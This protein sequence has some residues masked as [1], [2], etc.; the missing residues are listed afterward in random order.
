[1]RTRVREALPFHGVFYGLRSELERLRMEPVAAP[2]GL[3]LATTIFRSLIA[4]QRT[5]SPRREKTR[6]S[7]HNRSEH[8]REAK[9]EQ[10]HTASSR[11]HSVKHTAAPREVLGNHR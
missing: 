8:E 10:A 7:S 4:D 1:M 2:D 3:Q 11:E 9:S 6:A 5:N